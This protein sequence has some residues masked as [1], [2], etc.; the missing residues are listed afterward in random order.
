M[1]NETTRGNGLMA[2]AIA[3]C[4]L[5]GSGAAL[6]QTYPSKPI[7]LIV[8][9]PPGGVIDIAGRVIAQGLSQGLGQP[10]IVENRPGVAGT[11]GLETAAK[12]PADGYTLAMGTTGTLASAP[13]LYP[14]LGYDPGRSFAPISLLT[15]APFLVVVH[16]GVPAQSLRELIEVARSRPGQL[17]FGSVGSGSPPHIA[18]EMFKVAAGVDLVHVP[19]KGLPPA[20]TDLVAGRTQLMFN[21]LAPF[22]PH[23]GDG[24]L[25]VLAVAAPGRAAQLP[26]VPTASEAGLPGYEVS[27]W[28]GL[29]APSGTPSG[30]IARLNAEALKALATKEVRDS[31][32][33]Q[34]FEP[35]GSTPEQFGAFIASEATRWAGAIKASGAKV[36]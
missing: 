27:I 33:A 6:S 17:N 2:A 9:F 21:Q 15:N 11:L 4:A 24:K 36:D 28:S 16:A 7:R 26:A 35:S 3:L 12:S 22:L 1:T 25:R 23:L 30:V 29:L 32:S 13:S 8:S 34:G 5:L 20:V 31:L 18:G 19:Y 10:V 14:S